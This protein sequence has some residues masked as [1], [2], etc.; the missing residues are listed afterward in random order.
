MDCLIQLKKE[1][2]TGDWLAPLLVWI[3][4]MGIGLALVALLLAPHE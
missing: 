3:V 1:I 2:R 4:V